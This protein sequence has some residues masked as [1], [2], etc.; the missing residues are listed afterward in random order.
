MFSIQSIYCIK[1]MLINQFRHFVKCLPFFPGILQ[2]A[3]KFQ[4]FYKMPKIGSH[5]IK[6]LKRSGILQKCLN[7]E[8]A[9]NIYMYFLSLMFFTRYLQCDHLKFIFMFFL[10]YDCCLHV[11]T[12]QPNFSYVMLFISDNG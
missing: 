2:N 9:C 5:F 7:Y 12:K 1:I 3:L 4:S 6:R 10:Y 11:L 8:I